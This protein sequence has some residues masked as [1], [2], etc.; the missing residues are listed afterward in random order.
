[1]AFDLVDDGSHAFT[2]LAATEFEFELELWPTTSQPMVDDPSTAV[3]SP[4]AS[5]QA[6]PLGVFGLSITFLS[7]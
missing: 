5:P 1:V 3:A 4:T 7:K 6:I 2:P